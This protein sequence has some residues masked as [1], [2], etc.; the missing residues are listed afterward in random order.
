MMFLSCWITCIS[1]LKL[2]VQREVVT[3]DNPIGLLYG[4]NSNID[5]ELTLSCLINT[6]LGGTIA[7]PKSFNFSP[8]V[9]DSFL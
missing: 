6:K 8:L 3:E 5:G 2:K 9:S 4:N 7:K 1:G